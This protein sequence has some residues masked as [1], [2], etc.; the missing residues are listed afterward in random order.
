MWFCGPRVFKHTSLA[1]ASWRAPID[2][3]KMFA[4]LR[5]RA[6]QRAD[7]ATLIDLRDRG[8]WWEPPADR[9]A[10]DHDLHVVE[11]R[12]RI[13]AFARHTQRGVAAPNFAPEPIP[14]L[15]DIRSGDQRAL[16]GDG[17]L[18]A[19]QLLD[20]ELLAI[21]RLTRTLP[22]YEAGARWCF[23]EVA[24]PQHPTLDDAAVVQQ[25]AAGALPWPLLSLPIKDGYWP[26]GTRA[27]HVIAVRRNDEF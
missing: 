25:I 19:P 23:I 3:R 27:G 10:F 8:V 12:Y 21:H 14:T 2:N 18:V 24:L 9:E 13:V 16:L 17:L 11:L 20:D 5:I 26:L 22:A 15:H 4:N 6:L 7:H 1:L